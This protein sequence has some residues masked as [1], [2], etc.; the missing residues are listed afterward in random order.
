MK[1][2]NMTTAATLRRRFDEMRSVPVC[3][4]PL[5]ECVATVY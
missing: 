4:V 5:D 2:T 1:A 3:F